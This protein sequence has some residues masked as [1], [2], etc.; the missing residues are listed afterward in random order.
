VRVARFAARLGFDVAP[1]TL[2]LMQEMVAQGEAD[3]LVPENFKALHIV[4]LPG[5]EPSPEFLHRLQDLSG[6][7]LA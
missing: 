3:A 4:R 2:A 7:R 5:G 6:R 1:E